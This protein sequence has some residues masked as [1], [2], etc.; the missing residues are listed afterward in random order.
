MGLGGTLPGTYGAGSSGM[1]ICERSDT[2]RASSC[3]AASARRLLSSSTRWNICM[4]VASDSSLSDSPPHTPARG[5]PRRRPWSP[6]LLVRRARSS[7]SACNEHGCPSE[8]NLWRCRA[9]SGECCHDT[10]IRAREKRVTGGSSG[11][12]RQG[13][14]Y[15]SCVRGSEPETPAC[16]DGLPGAEGRAT[17]GALAGRGA[18]RLRDGGRRTPRDSRAPRCDAR[19]LGC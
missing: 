9:G 16:S 17:I 4:R 13:C 11:R 10:R 8:A 12:R 2:V 5:A 19:R 15:S 3:A 14:R 7:C 18:A 1:T 6:L